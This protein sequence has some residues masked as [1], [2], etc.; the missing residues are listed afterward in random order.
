[1]T[2]IID[3]AGT[4]T[5]VFRSNDPVFYTATAA[6]SDETDATVLPIYSS[7]TVVVVTSDSSAK[8][9]RI[10]SGGVIGDTLDIIAGASDY[11]I[12]APNGDLMGSSNSGRRL[13]LLP[14]G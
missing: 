13:T 2:T 1:M 6:G 9:V 7:R 14:S 5:I 4:P 11:Q 12:Y 10:D 3:P 8:G